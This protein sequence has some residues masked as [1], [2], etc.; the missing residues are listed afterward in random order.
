MLSALISG[1]LEFPKQ[2]AV[3]APPVLPVSASSHPLNLLLAFSSPIL[4]PLVPGLTF[5]LTLLLT[6]LPLSHMMVTPMMPL[7]LL[8]A[9][10]PSKLSSSEPKRQ[11][12]RNNLL[13][14][15]LITYSP[16]KVFLMSL[17]PTVTL[18]S[19]QHSGKLYVIPSLFLNIT[20]FHQEID[21]CP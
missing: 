20:V 9:C 13:I 14:S 11:S 12:T 15:S 19:H 7:L 18:G 16:K 1:G 10:S 3:T 4:Y 2:F 6:F 17:S 21:T 8:C 5:P